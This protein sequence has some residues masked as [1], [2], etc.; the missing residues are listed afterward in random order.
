LWFLL[1]IAAQPPTKKSGILFP[2]QAL[3]IVDRPAIAPRQTHNF[4]ELLSQNQPKLQKFVPK[5]LL[6]CDGQSNL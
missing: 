6:F 4:C 3:V 1:A 2:K 5:L